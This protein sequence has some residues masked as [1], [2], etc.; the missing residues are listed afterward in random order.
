MCIYGGGDPQ[1]ICKDID[2]FNEFWQISDEN[3]IEEWQ[4][5]N[6]L[7]N[8]FCQRNLKALNDTVQAIIR[9][10]WEW[11]HSKSSEQQKLTYMFFNSLSSHLTAICQM[12]CFEYFI[13]NDWKILVI[14]HGLQKVEVC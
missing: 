5:Y 6:E 13:S 9:W 11:E 14:S 10:E 1:S 7:H 4:T 8:S 3:I 2:C 12:E